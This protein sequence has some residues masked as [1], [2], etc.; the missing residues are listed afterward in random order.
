MST[1]VEATFD[2][3]VFRPS[4]P[5]ALS[6]NTQ[7]RLTIEP[8]PVK[9]G[10]PGSFLETALSLKLEGP[11]D[12]SKNLHQYLYGKECRSEE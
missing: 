4:I 7:V 2:G 11:P 8:L 10:K 3:S 12:F 9:S 6:P 5:V 1:T